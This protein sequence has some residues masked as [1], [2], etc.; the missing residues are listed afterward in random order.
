MTFVEAENVYDR[1]NV[2]QYVWN[3]K[4]RSRDTASQIAFLPLGGVTIE[5][6]RGEKHRARLR[7]VSIRYYRRSLTCSKQAS[8]MP[9]L[10][11]AAYEVPPPA[12]HYQQ[13]WRSASSKGPSA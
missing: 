8:K 10:T 9:R 2:F 11:G 1:A 6:W 3:P 7:A 12:T 13:I 4:T 5:I